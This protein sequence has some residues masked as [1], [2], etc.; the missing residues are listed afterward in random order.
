MIQT[1]P[2]NGAISDCTAKLTVKTRSGAQFEPS[3]SIGQSP[4]PAAPRAFWRLVN[5]GE[6]AGLLTAFEPGAIVEAFRSGGQKRNAVDVEL[7]RFKCSLTDLYV[8]VTLF[9][10][11]PWP[12]SLQILARETC[13]DPCS[14]RKSLDHLEE[15]NAIFFKDRADTGSAFQL[16]PSGQ[17]LAVFLMYRVINAAS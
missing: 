2:S 9:A 11:V 14:L 16:T 4:Y 17:T 7:T 6:M 3:E 8:L 15:L 1:Q 13:A 12:V 10:A 5:I